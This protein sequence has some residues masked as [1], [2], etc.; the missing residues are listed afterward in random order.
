MLYKFCCKHIYIFSL[1]TSIFRVSVLHLSS[2]NN[3]LL[4]S[5]YSPYL[6]PVT[7]LV[8]HH[9]VFSQSTDCVYI[10]FRH[11]SL[12]AKY[13][14]SILL[15]LPLGQVYFAAVSYFHLQFLYY[16]AAIHTQPLG[17][18]CFSYFQKYDQCICNQFIPC[19]K[20][21]KL[22]LLSVMFCYWLCLEILEVC[23]YNR[24]LYTR[25]LSLFQQPWVNS[26]C[27]A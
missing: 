27:Y 24:I 3:I 21:I 25:L 23:A 9:R 12:P 14:H 11:M 13:L 19:F 6:C 7:F 26:E 5:L 1:H 20:F 17:T 22:C 2:P 16:P 10:A 8:S 18:I 15:Q 4:S